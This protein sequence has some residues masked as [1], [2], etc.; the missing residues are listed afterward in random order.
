[1]YEQVKEK[2]PQDFQKYLEMN[3][4]SK[5][6]EERTGAFQKNIMSASE[7]LKSQNLSTIDSRQL[8]LHNHFQS[9]KQN[10]DKSY[11]GGVSFLESSK[12]AKLEDLLGVN[13][14]D[15]QFGDIKEHL[16]GQFA[17]QESEVN[18]EIT[19]FKNSEVQKIKN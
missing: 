2:S 17:K 13:T 10:V 12:Q 18:Q 19:A 4:V 7:D 8:E 15:K 11:P 9:I 1:M 16:K 3:E 14:V 5:H 6:I